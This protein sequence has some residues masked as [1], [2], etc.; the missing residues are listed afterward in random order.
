MGAR[1]VGLGF[2]RAAG[3]CGHALTSVATAVGEYGDAGG[4]RGDSRL[5]E[6]RFPTR[7][8]RGLGGFPGN[9]DP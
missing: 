4:V 7:R 6:V 1:V 2:R 3:L 5:P 9:L 8:V